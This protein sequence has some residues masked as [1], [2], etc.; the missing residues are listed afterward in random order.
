MEEKLKFFPV[1]LFAVIMG[2][3]G[4]TIVYSK[5][6]HFFYFPRIIYLSLLALDTA[7]FFT[8]FLLYM[9][10]TLKYFE[11]VKEEFRHPIKSSFIPAISIC[12][13]LLS[14]AYYDFAPTVSVVYW[15]LGTIAHFIFTIKIIKFWINE[16][17]NILNINPAWFIPIVRNVLIPVIGVDI[18]PNYVSYFF[19]SIGIFFW[20]ILLAIL[21]YRA[22]FH[23]KF[24]DRLI[25]TFL[26][27]IAP[28]AVGFISYLRITF[29][30]NDFISQGLYFIG[31]FFFIL[32]LT[33][34]DTF[35]KLK[36]AISWWAYTFPLSAITIATILQFMIFRNN[37]YKFLSFLLILITTI[38]VLIVSYKT[39][40][41]I[42]KGKICVPEGG[43]EK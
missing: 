34:F 7:V 20:I 18:V 31:L 25:P 2:L 30:S 37:F 17:F 39:L 16:D 27:L 36:F 3:S 35:K 26:I 21:L 28:A 4:L 43:E 14:I 32:F 13:L 41:A 24:P 5:T 8:I 12:I 29:G 1:Q 6:Y 19:F 40:L 22:I 23:K 33:M 42:K 15:L 38:V 9:L 10:K 11:N